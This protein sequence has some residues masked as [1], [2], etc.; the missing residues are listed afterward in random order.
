MYTICKK[1]HIYIYVAQNETS[2]SRSRLGDRVS[3]TPPPRGAAP[4]WP[5]SLGWA[6]TTVIFRS[7]PGLSG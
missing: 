7:E 4:W 5:P 2:R 1:K 3:R 6:S